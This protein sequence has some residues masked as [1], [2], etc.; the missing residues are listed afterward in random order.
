MLRLILRKSAKQLEDDCC[1]IGL[2][3]RPTLEENN[4]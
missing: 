3:A 4:L 1:G 2:K